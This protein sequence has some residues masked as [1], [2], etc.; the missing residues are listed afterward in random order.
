MPMFDV[1]AVLPLVPCQVVELQEEAT[2][3]A[4]AGLPAAAGVAMSLLQLP[5]FGGEEPLEL[6]DYKSRL[7][8]VEQ[9]TRCDVTKTNL[10]RLCTV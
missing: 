6:S 8:M 1:V 3:P 7:V 9:W 5:P 10:I 2:G 4:F